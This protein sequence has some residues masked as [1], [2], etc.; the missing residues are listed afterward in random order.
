VY[1]IYSFYEDAVNIFDYAESIIIIIIII[2]IILY[3]WRRV[4]L[5]QLV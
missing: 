5:E 4:L 3:T 1:L 2:I